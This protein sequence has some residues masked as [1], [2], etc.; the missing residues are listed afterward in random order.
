MGRAAS[1]RGGLSDVGRMQQRVTRD[2]SWR[3]VAD[4]VDAEAPAPIPSHPVF[5]GGTGRSGTTIV[6]KLIG[7]HPE[8]QFIR[9]EV[10]LHAARGSLRD[11]ALGTVDFDW[12][13]PRL[14][15]YWYSPPGARGN[16]AGLKRVCTR[17]HYD[18][19]LAHLRK[20]LAQEGNSALGRF[21]HELLD[22]VAEAAG[23][24]RWVE[25]TPANAEAGPALLRMFPDMKLV[26]VTRSGL[27]VA[28]SVCAVP[29]GPSDLRDCIFFWAERY[30]AAVEGTRLLPPSA[31]LTISLEDLAIRQPEA[32]YARLRGFLGV[33]DEREMR[34]FFDEDVTAEAARSGRWRE[35]LSPRAQRR[36]LS[37]YAYERSR[38]R[39]RGILRLPAEPDLP[40]A[41]DAVR[42]SHWLWV[43]W[44][45]VVWRS[46][47]RRWLQG[48]RRRGPTPGR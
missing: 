27:D 16:P 37:L 30:H 42:L 45:A 6:A 2:Y 36:L 17:E 11:L 13:W 7:A 3:P 8:I 34:R 22:P 12:L 19:A 40:A 14:R 41:D 35:G 4:P 43:R 9:A 39:R 38:L 46:R 1:A 31:A 24:S 28:A 25:M 5:V 10:R 47:R 32:T 23:A 20:R 15:A 33:R 44:R 21:L 48:S 29:W 26:H 18:L